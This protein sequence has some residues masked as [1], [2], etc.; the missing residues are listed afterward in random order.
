MLKRILGIAMLLALVASG[1]NATLIAT[2]SQNPHV[3]P[4][5]NAT[6]DGTTTNISI[7]DISTAVTSGIS[8]LIGNAIF[9][10]N[11]TSVDAAATLGS[12]VIQHYSGSF[13]FTSANGCGGTN[14]LSGTFTDAAFGALGGPGLTVNVNNPPDT[15]VLTSSVIASSELQAP[16]TFGLTFANLTPNL[17][18]DGTTIGAFTAD[19]AG[20]VSA[21]SVPEP[22]S[23]GLLGI[24]LFGLGMVRYKR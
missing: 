7:L 23:L 9:D 13:C 3:G 18:I 10:F 8:G 24:G 14:F 19:F 20:T 17:H 12:A 22:F 21:S 4:T 2:F 11:A 15:L 1:A 6:D 5:V 16:S